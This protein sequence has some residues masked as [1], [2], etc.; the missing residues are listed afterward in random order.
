MTLDILIMFHLKSIYLISYI[1]TWPNHF[2]L[3][4]QTVLCL[5]RY[6]PPRDLWP[7]WRPVQCDDWFSTHPHKTFGLCGV[8]FS[9]MSGS[10]LTLMR[11]LACVN[12]VQCD[13]WFSTYPHE[14]FGLCD[15]WLGVPEV[16]AHAI[17]RHIAQ[18]HPPIHLHHQL[19]SAQFMGFL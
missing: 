17:H 3:N 5:V 11:L 9:V 6:L 10:V 1:I 19:V 4:L 15:V 8:R 12:L 2:P 16:H 18:F 7:V 13:L 14:T